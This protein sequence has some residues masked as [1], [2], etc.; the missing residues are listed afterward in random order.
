[1]RPGKSGEFPAKDCTAA[2]GYST[3]TSTLTIIMNWNGKSLSLQN[4]QNP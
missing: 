2:G 1:V 3:S 4:A